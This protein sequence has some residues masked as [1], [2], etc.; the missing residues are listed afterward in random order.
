MAS[1]YTATG[2]QL[3]LASDGYSA[4]VVTVGAGL[5][6]FSYQGRQLISGYE[7]DELPPAS[8]GIVLAPWP[9]RIGDGHYRFAGA[10][11][12]LPITEVARG[13]AMHGLVFPIEWRVVEQTDSSALLGLRLQ[14]TRGY[15]FR[16][17][18]QIV[19]E[20]SADGL[21]V[22]LHTTNSGI[23]DAPYGCGAHPYL[24]AGTTTVDD[25]VLQ[26]AAEQRLE[27]DDRMLPIDR[28]AVPGTPYDFSAA[29]AIGDL[30]LDT[31]FTGLTYDA[32]GIGRA[33]LTDPQTGTGVQLWWDATHR[34]VQLYTADRPD[35]AQNRIALAVEPMTCPPDAFRSGD[36]LITLAPGE[37]HRSTWGI[38]AL[39]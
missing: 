38:R 28:I 2:D 17:D 3:V 18:L 1:D 29:R 34:W 14:P 7:V 22:T 25:T 15:P 9:N 26:F 31:A 16:L 21:R 10:E 35:P 24:T 4:T 12:Q 23:R 5:R 36:D 19:Y 8:R 39:G 27:V 20:L 13:N 30:V 32:D 33:T 6:L 37:T 11:Y